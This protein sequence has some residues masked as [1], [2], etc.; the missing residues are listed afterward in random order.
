ME[1]NKNK[2]HPR[3][4]IDEKL[5]KI[6]MK[7]PVRGLIKSKHSHF[8]HLGIAVNQYFKLLKAMV[9]I[10]LLL[11]FLSLPTYYIFGAG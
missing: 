10:Y 8:D 3:I 6:P 1:L 4:N 5:K 7:V 11:A 9:K 2:M